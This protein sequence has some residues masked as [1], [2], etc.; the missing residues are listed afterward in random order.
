MAP[1][2]TGKRRAKDGLITSTPDIFCARCYDELLAPMAASITIPCEPTWSRSVYHLYVIRAPYRDELQKHLTEVGVGTEIHYP[3]LFTS[4]R[5]IPRWGGSVEIFRC[6]RKPLTKSC[7]CRCLLGYNLSNRIEWQR[8][9][10]SSLRFA[11]SCTSEL[12]P[13]PRSCPRWLDKSNH[14]SN[15]LLEETKYARRHSCISSC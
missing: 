7:R 6:L 15:M 11:Q 3:I 14:H 5:P 13:S 12:H 8:R 4:K 9:W 10:Q 1:A 2:P